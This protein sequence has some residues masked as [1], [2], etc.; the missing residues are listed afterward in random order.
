MSVIEVNGARLEYVEAGAGEPLVFVHGSL[1]DLRIWW[2]QVEPFSARYRVVA[3]SR[4]YHYP[5]A[6]PADG[7]KYSAALHADDLAGLIGELGL[8]PAHLVT[9]SF[10]GCVALQLAAA[11]PELVRSLVLAEPPLMP[12][13]E[14]I[15]GGAP[16]AAAFLADAWEPAQ[17]AFREGHFEQG[18]RSF[19]DGVVGRGAFD[20]LSPSGRRMVMDNAPEMKA[21]TQAQDFFPRLGCRDVTAIDRP[22]LLLTG[23]L[24]P[25]MFHLIIDEL[26][27]C[28][29]QSV[30]AVIPGASHAIHVGNPQVYNDA[31]LEFLAENRWM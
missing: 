9:S 14:R 10:G 17:R 6:V 26:A 19:L 21:E 30:T 25:R 27:R 16:L 29:P 28:L 12:W 1:E 7:A 18:V 22:A 3:Y 20:C 15:P 5:N 24:S 31:V 13:L 8:A 23:E 4:R 11:R 2:R